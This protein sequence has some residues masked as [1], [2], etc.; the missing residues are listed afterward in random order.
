MEA[1]AADEEDDDDVDKRELQFQQH[2]YGS[3][4]STMTGDTDVQDGLQHGLQ[5]SNDEESANTWD[6]LDCTTVN[7]RGDLYQY[8]QQKFPSLPALM[9]LGKFLFVVNWR[10][11]PVQFVL[12]FA[13]DLSSE[14]FTSDKPFARLFHRFIAMETDERNKRLKVIPRVVEGPWFV[15][16]AIGETPAIIGTKIDTEYHNGYRYMEASIDVYSSAVA[17]HIVSLVTDAAKRLVIDIGFVIEGQSDDELP[18]RM[19]GG[20]RVRYPDLQSL[21]HLEDPE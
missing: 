12:T 2:Y 3:A 9:T 6:R 1:R 16:R 4:A 18:E 7:V 5:W 20:F 14:I 11:T 13:V 15:K 8:D 19:L 17:R 21:R 10:M